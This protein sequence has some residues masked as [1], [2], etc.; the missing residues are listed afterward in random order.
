MSP[1]V[2]SVLEF[3]FNEQTSLKDHK[4]AESEVAFEEEAL[5]QEEIANLSSTQIR[6]MTCGELARAV[7]ASHLPALRVRPEY[8]DR[9]TLERLAYVGRLA[10]R[11]RQQPRATEQTEARKGRVGCT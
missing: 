4:V 7:R 11:N 6:H 2:D 9:G 10:C 1:K 5:D 3:P 8:L